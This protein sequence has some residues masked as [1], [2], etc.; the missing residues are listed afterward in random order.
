VIGTRRSS[1]DLPWVDEPTNHVGGL[2]AD[3]GLTDEIDFRVFGAASEQKGDGADVA[4]WGAGLTL[5]YPDWNALLV[6]EAIGTD[7]DP[8]VGF[9]QRGGVNQ[10]IIGL[11]HTSQ[12]N[13]SL[14]LP[15][16]DLSVRRFDNHANFQW[17]DRRHGDRETRF[18]HLH[19]VVV[20]AG[21]SELGIIYENSY[22]RLFGP[23]PLGGDVVFPEG[24]YD[25]DRW[26][27]NLG[28][29]PSR[30]FSASLVAYDGGFFDADQRSLTVTTAF[31][32]PPHVT[33]SVEYELE[34]IERVAADG[35]EQEFASDLLRL[36]LEL[37]VSNSL[38]LNLFTQWNETENLL[39][40]QI[41]GHYIFGDESDVYVVIA[42]DRADG[43]GD[44]NPRRG[45]WT[46]K[47]NYARRL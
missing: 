1:E 16:P 46:L 45:E 20:G 40:S 47:F 19:P 23:F 22:E 32:M 7:Y 15:G 3:L 36:R 42:D 31:L 28:T 10:T 44:F 14:S 18:I 9:V 6:Q 11:G 21:E 17:I 26:G 2:D 33:T 5:A 12:P 38:T 25:F 39:L 8:Q 43:S 4:T 24:G 29:D 30:T 41:R 37:D 27:V 34:R 13:W 35:L